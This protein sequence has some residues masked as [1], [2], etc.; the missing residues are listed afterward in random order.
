MENDN[1]WVELA[2]DVHKYRISKRTSFG[3]IDSYF[4]DNILSKRGNRKNGSPLLKLSINHKIHSKNF[5]SDK[6]L[7]KIQMENM[8]IW[9]M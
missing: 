8:E 5:V 3:E 6:I 4:F 7:I 1:T 2:F 9:M